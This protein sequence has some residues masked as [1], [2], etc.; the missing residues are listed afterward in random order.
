MRSGD[1]PGLLR[2][3]GAEY[4]VCFSYASENR[5][6]VRKTADLVSKMGIRLFYDEHKRAEVWGKNLRE[7]LKQIYKE[8]AKFCVVFISKDY[9]SKK[10]TMHEL[11]SVLERT[12]SD[13]FI[14]TVRF[15]D[16]EIPGFSPD[17]AYIDSRKYLPEQLAELIKEKLGELEKKD[18]SLSYGLVHSYE[19]DEMKGS[20]AADAVS[21]NTLRR[22][23]EPG[24]G[25]S[26]GSGLMFG[27]EHRLYWTSDKPVTMGESFSVSASVLLSEH[28]KNQW[29]TAVAQDSDDVSSFFLQYSTWDKEKNWAFALPEVH[30]NLMRAVASGPLR[31]GVWVQLV[32]V[33]DA[34]AKELRLYVDG[35]LDGRGLFPPGRAFHGRL[36]IGR[37]RWGDKPKDWFEGN[38]KQVKVW[39]RALSIED[40][41]T[42]ASGR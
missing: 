3:S 7:Y 4:D 16:T 31:T 25:G 38:I 32:G 5:E 33:A 15:D 28:A 2:K 6:Y 11:D 39:N 1:T 42:L 8:K 36:T 9:A 24:W 21:G 27:G 34:D 14:L 18:L 30:P 26:P 19:L 22:R 35:K 37:A 40:V 10:W 12:P 20:T 41:A 13:R 23:D 17:E 29:C